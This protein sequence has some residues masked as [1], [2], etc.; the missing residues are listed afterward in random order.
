M[1]LLLASVLLELLEPVR[2]AS[3]CSNDEVLELAELL[4]EALLNNADKSANSAES[5]ESADWLEAVDVPLW[6][7]CA[8]GLMEIISRI[9]S[10]PLL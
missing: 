2:L 6:A 1:M 4:L 3:N 5:S 7:D 9:L 8:A 10:N